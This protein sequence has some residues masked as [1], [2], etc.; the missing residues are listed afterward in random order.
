[1]T[2]IAP[3]AQA[4]YQEFCDSYHEENPQEE[5]LRTWEQLSPT[6][7]VEWQAQAGEKTEAD[8]T[9]ARSPSFEEHMATKDTESVINEDGTQIL[10]KKKGG[11]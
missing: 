7:Q 8:V 1:M 10:R 9:R 3:K 6:E 4:L 11:Q 2:V 5:R